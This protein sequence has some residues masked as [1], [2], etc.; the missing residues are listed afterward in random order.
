MLVLRK[1]DVSVIF[2]ICTATA[3]LILSPECPRLLACRFAMFNIGLRN[4]SDERFRVQNQ[5]V[6][7]R[8]A[9]CD[10]DELRKFGGGRR[11]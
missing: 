6:R 9:Q 3:F 11:G 10:D 8:H 1:D 7:S 5:T 2:Y 4:S